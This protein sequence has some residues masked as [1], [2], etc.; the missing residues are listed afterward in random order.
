EFTSTDPQVRH[1]ELDN[2][3]APSLTQMA[4]QYDCFYL[5][6][7]A[8]N[9]DDVS[10]LLSLDPFLDADF[11][12]DANDIP[13]NLLAQLQRN[14]RTWAYPLNLQPQVLWYHSQLFAEAG[15]P[16]PEGGWTTDAFNDALR[17]LKIDADD[18][19][20]FQPRDFGGNYILMLTAA[21]GG[22]P[23][24]YRTQPVTVNFTDLATVE[25]LRQV[26]DL[27]KQGYIQYQQ[28][29]TTGG[30]FGG[31][32]SDTPIYTDTLSPFS[33]NRFQ[34]QQQNTDFVDPYRITSYPTGSQYTPVT[35]SIGTA[36]ISATSPIPDACYRWISTLGEHPELF[37][38]MPARRSQLNNPEL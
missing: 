12:F 16:A 20:P 17:S 22:L 11:N 31:G 25:A 3:S 21:Y 5:P 38:A 10:A 35:Y 2:N 13:G 33:F 23:L 19:P 1:I 29:A 15:I 14:N 18:P 6:F 8:A 27:A 37:M 36:Y 26:L 32:G 34:F 24:D 30:V 9:S 4:E 7:N 28:L